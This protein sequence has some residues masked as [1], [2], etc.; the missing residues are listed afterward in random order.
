MIVVNLQSIL[1]RFFGFVVAL[2]HVATAY[3][4]D[5]FNFGRLVFD[6]IDFTTFDAGAARGQAI[7]YY[8]CRDIQLKRTIQ[9]FTQFCE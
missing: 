9:F 6:V 7:D 3:I 8:V 5:T 2:N 1:D 4:A